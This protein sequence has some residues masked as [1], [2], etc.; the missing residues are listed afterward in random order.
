[1]FVGGL[2]EGD[3]AKVGTGVDDAKVGTGV[4]TDWGSSK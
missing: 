4:G 1:M 2:G 3:G